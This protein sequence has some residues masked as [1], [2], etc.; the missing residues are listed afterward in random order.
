MIVQRLPD[1]SLNPQWI[2]ERQGCLGASQ[3]DSILDPTTGDAKEG[4][5]KGSPSQMR[6]TLARQ[7]A[8]ERYA[9]HSCGY[10]N[11][12]DPDIKRGNDLE[13][14][15]LAEYEMKYGVFLRPA[16]W[17]EHPELPFSGATPDGFRPDGGLVQVKAPRLDNYYSLVLAGEFPADYLAQCTWEQAVTRAP[18]TDL[19]LYCEEMPEGQKMWV[20][21]YTAPTEL[22]VAYEVQVKAFLAEVEAY[23]DAITRVEFV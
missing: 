5:K 4:R 10:A 9:G 21:R 6:M 13:P 2:K 1:G 7:L 17:V 12:N 11:P 3:I 22:I 19:V 16:A 14:V 20:K 23:F 18:F 15:A 8:A